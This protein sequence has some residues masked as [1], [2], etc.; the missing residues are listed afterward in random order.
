MRISPVTGLLVLMLAGCSSPG[1]ERPGQEPSAPPE[2]VEPVPPTPGQIGPTPEP[3]RLPAVTVL[4]PAELDASL[5]RF[6]Q[7]LAQTE[8]AA[9]LAPGEVGYYLDV[10][11]AR[12]RQTLRD[13]GIGY[14]R[15]GERVRIELPAAAAFEINSARPR[16]EILRSL[17]LVAEA[18]G[19]FTQMMVSVHG[20][21]DS[22][23]PADTN[24]SLSERRALAVAEELIRRGLARRHLAAVGHGAD[25]PIT[26][27]ATPEGQARNRRVELWIEPL[28]LE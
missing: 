27:D 12:L 19:P 16:P 26:T 15:E 1:S 24:R 18:I 22:S 6:R 20:H 9:V 7:A 25:R 23:G 8:P 21:T 2:S 17:D 5:L 4:D 3:K 13:S 10:L 14:R 11:D 28:V